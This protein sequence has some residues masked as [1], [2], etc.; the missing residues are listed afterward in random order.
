M[1]LLV[2]GSATPHLELVHPV[3]RIARVR[4]AVDQ[5]RHGDQARGVDD[6]RAVVELEALA[7]L[8]AVAD[9][10]DLA[11]IGGDPHVAVVDLD[12]AELAAAQ[13]LARRATRGRDLGEA[14]DHEVRRDALFG[15]HLGA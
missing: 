8:I 1:D 14:A 7:H 4:V 3:A 5:A 12:G 9:G 11:S 13:G 2:G 6:D 10:G 15:A